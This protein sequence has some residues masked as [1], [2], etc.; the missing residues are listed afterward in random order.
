MQAN[1][2]SLRGLVALYPYPPPEDDPRIH[3]DYDGVV[4]LT[5]IS[6]AIDDW[7]RSPNLRGVYR[8]LS[9]VLGKT[10]VLKMQVGGFKYSAI[11]IEDVLGLA[12]EIGVVIRDIVAGGEPIYW[13][14]M[15]CTMLSGMGTLMWAVSCVLLAELTPGTQRVP[16][17]GPRAHR[18]A[19]QR[20]Y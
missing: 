14:D 8:L 6:S 20:R 17:R 9:G 15:S 11:S 4:G 12:E 13:S 7:M 3:T 16:C 5:V 18:A 19:V 10:M 2:C 1:D